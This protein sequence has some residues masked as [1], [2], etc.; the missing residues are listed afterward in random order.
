MSDKHAPL[1]LLEPVCERENHSRKSKASKPWQKLTF[2]SVAQDNERDLQRRRQTSGD[3]TSSIRSRPDS[4]FDR[5]RQASQDSGVL[6]MCGDRD[7]MPQV[8]LE[9]DRCAS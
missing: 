7:G 2:R 3:S 9:Y 4:G 6:A 5:L 8:V 1:T